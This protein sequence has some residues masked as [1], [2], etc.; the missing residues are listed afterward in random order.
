M[1]QGSR[2]RL[3]TVLIL[4]LVFGSGVLLGLAADSSLSA[5]APSDVVSAAGD[6]PEDAA[7]E[8]AE[9]ETERRYIYDEV[10]PNEE[11]LARIQVIVAEWRARREAFDEDSRTQWEQG[12]REFVIETRN[13]IK[14]VLSPE[15]AAEYQRLLDEWE[16]ERAAEREN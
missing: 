12:R 3:A 8:P 11:Q 5:E 10:D 16:A 6:P 13:A 4:V 9:P 14:A 15:Q 2:T 7:E 1:E